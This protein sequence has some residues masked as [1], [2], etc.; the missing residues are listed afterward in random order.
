MAQGFPELTKVHQDFIRKQH[1]F[2][3]GTAPA[4][5]TGDVN[6]S[7]KGY[8]SFRILSSNEA[9]YLDLTGSG[10]ETSGHLGENHRIAVMF[11]A[12]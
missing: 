6:L 3:M 10:H 1:L 11:C 12:F 2:F 9:A 4:N 5:R 7:P 8:D